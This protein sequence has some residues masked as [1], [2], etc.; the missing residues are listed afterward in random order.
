M[1]DGFDLEPKSIDFAKLDADLTRAKLRDAFFRD[2][3]HNNHF[4]VFVLTII[5]TATAAFVS[6]K[7]TDIEFVKELWKIVIPVITAYMGYAIGDRR[8]K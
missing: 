5:V 2:L 7:S 6:L 1:S 8:R 3:L 4:Y